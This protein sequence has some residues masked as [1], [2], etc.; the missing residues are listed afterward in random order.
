MFYYDNGKLQVFANT[1]CGSTNMHHY[2]NI[3]VNKQKRFPSAYSEDL[4]IVI[5]NPLDRLVSATRGIPMVPM[6]PISVLRNLLNTGHTSE[7]MTEWGIFYVHCKPYFAVIKDK[8]FKI[9]DFNRLNEYIPRNT[10]RQ[11]SPT[12]NS[13]GYTDPK[14]V[15]VE[16]Q[17]FTLTDLEIEYET[18]LELLKDREQISVAEW[19]EKTT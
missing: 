19:K 15:Y 17:Y 12:T 14:T 2:F 9:I 1:R 18:Y 5:R 13:S 11:Q 10:A 4:T 7:S 3:D 8:P 6:I 16:N